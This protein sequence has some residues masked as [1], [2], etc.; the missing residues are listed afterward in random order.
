MSVVTPSRNTGQRAKLNF[1]AA[2]GSAPIAGGFAPETLTNEIPPFQG[3]EISGGYRSQ[4]CPPA[5]HPMHCMLACLPLLCM[6]QTLL[7]ALQTLPSHATRGELMQRVCC[8]GCWRAKLSACM[9][10]S[11]L[12]TH[13]WSCL[14]PASTEVWRRRSRKSRLLLRRPGPRRRF[15]ANGLFQLPGLLLLKPRS[16]ASP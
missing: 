3:A 9:A 1:A 14:T 13:A 15:R 16:Q 10:L 5:S 6:I 11:P 2:T 12:N 7:C 4:G 8:A